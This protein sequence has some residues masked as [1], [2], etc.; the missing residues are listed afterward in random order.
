MATCIMFHCQLE[1]LH[2]LFDFTFST[3]LAVFAAY[4]FTHKTLIGEILPFPEVN[5]NIK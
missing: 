2:A 1:I 4:G 3:R 5:L